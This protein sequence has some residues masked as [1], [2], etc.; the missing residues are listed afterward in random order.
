MKNE[1]KK[2]SSSGLGKTRQGEEEKDFQRGVR[3]EERELISRAAQA[4]AGL[5]ESDKRRFWRRVN[6]N[7]P[8]PDQSNLNYFGLGNCWEWTGACGSGGYGAFQLK[9]SIGSH[10]VSWVIH[11]RA[12]PSRGLGVLHKCDNRKCVNP[13]H[14]FEGS[15]R[16]NSADM[17]SKGRHWTVS[18]PEKLSRGPRHSEIIARVSQKGA[19]HYLARNPDKIL[20]GDSAGAAKLTTEQVRYIKLNAGVISQQKLADKFGVSRSAISLIHIGKNWPH[21]NI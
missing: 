16:V 8:M 15:Q 17:V 21:I 6:K 14:L 1:T 19:N 5:S 7:G 2:S 18:N 4:L 9:I 13:D 11:G 12:L 20:R 3:E 10:R